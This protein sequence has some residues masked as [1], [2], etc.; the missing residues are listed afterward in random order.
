MRW[1]FFFIVLKTISWSFF[2]KKKLFP[3]EKCMGMLWC[4]QRLVAKLLELI[5]FPLD[6]L[7]LRFL[8]L[9]AEKEWENKDNRN[10]WR[11][12]N[13]QPN[14]KKNPLD[15][16]N[17]PIGLIF[18]L[19]RKTKKPK[20]KHFCRKQ[21]TQRIKFGHKAVIAIASQFSVVIYY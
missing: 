6:V 14:E 16:I 15:L 5:N 4:V 7:R 20:L 18:D 9:F 3:L 21:R 8:L 2:K 10:V 12:P 13:F 19:N 1:D 17:W 11:V